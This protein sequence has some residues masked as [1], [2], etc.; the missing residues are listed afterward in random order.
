MHDQRAIRHCVT[1]LILKV[2][3]RTFVTLKKLS[4][5]FG[6][7]RTLSF[8]MEFVGS[9]WNSTRN[10]CGERVGSVSVNNNGDEVIRP[11][12]QQCWHSSENDTG[13]L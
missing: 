2:P 13:L 1:R 12:V 11:R 7:E 3:H 9:T 6:W 5:E 4:L 10:I 8:H